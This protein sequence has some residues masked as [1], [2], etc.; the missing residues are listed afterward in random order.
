MA[1]SNWANRTIFTGDNLYVMRGMNSESVDL[2]YADP[3]FNSNRNYSAPVGS[4]AAG[5]AFKDAWMLSD[6]DLIEHNRLREENKG[7]FAAIAA[8][9]HTHSKGMFS[10]LVMM[11]LRLLEMRRL[12]KP[13]GSIYIHC[14]PFASHYLKVVMDAVFGRDN[15]RNEVVWK[16]TSS[17]SDANRFARVSDRLLFYAFDGA[18]WNTQYLPLG[19]TYVSRDYRHVD[20]KGR[21][22][23]GDLTGQGTS[24]G[25][26]GEPWQGFDPGEAGRHWSAP[27]T[28]NYAR[29]IEDNL[30]PGYM[31]MV[32]VHARLDALFSVGLIDRTES[33]YPR[34]KR[35]LVASRGEA[36]SDFVADI[37]NVN[38]RSKEHVGYPTQ[39]PIALLQRVIRASSNPGNIVFDPFAGCA[40]TLIAAQADG[41]E[42]VG[43]DLSQKAVDL[44]KQRIRDLTAVPIRVYDR[45]DIPLRTDNGAEL[46]VVEKQAHKAMLFVLQDQRCNGCNY[47]FPRP[48]DFHLDHIVARARGGT[49]HKENF[50]LLC[51]HCNAKKGAMPQEAFMAMMAQQKTALDWL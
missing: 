11:A 38:N 22:R 20:D 26:S 51:G 15:F 2:I 24:G 4:K 27:K 29:W 34:L 36:A 13:T 30:I 39:K 35:Y 21:Y 47:E 19:E 32:S 25:E 44:V 42:W 16:R 43:I 8:A 45:M 31:G 37:Q 12:L 50:Q 40:T 48:Q 10:Y 9:K 18:T 5:A 14:D 17:H 46:T 6:I 3:P 33:G 23:L 1:T 28:G 49:D 41:R 7:L